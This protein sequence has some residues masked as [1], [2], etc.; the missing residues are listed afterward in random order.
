MLD[1]RIYRAALVVV[2]LAA[3]VSAFALGNRP[4]PIG[5]TVPPDAFNGARARSDLDRLAS[6]YPS[7]RPGSSG[8]DAMAA[9]IAAELRGI[10]HSYDP[11]ALARVGVRLRALLRPTELLELSKSAA[12]PHG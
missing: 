6:Q 12:K 5:T 11:D 10:S 4:R 8:D 9:A 7:R 3:I 2:L 1:P